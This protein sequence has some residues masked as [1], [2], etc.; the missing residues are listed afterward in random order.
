MYFYLILR[1]D[2]EFY[3]I[4]DRRWVRFK[5]GCLFFKFYS[6]YWLKMNKTGKQ[7]NQPKKQM[8]KTQYL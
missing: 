4:A 3:I 1:I 8:N 5:V 2:I 6:I 7:T